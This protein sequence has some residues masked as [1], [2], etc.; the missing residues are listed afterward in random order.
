VGGLQA[1]YLGKLGAQAGVTG[2]GGTG[3]ERL[4]DRPESTEL[5]LRN[6]F[7]SHRP[8]RSGPRAAVVRIEDRRL[9]RSH[10]PMLGDRVT[11]DGIG[12]EQPPI[13]SGELDPGTD[14]PDG[15]RVA[16]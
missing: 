3:D 9:T 4:R 11:G 14:Q 13:P 16:G 10:Q 8:P 6:G 1:G 7:R 15:H 12:H 2:R 5:F